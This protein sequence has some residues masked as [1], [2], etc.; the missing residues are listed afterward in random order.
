MELH[1]ERLILRPVEE[2]DAP[3]L[4]PLINDP[5]I[6]ANMLNIPHP[7]PKG[8][9]APWIRAARE[10]ME[11]NERIEMSIIL[12]ETGLPIGACGL[13]Q[14]CWDHLNG[15]I[16]YWLGKPYWGHG[17]M[18]EAVK[19]LVDFGFNDLDLYRVFGRCFVNNTASAKVL[20]KAGLIYE[21]CARGEVMKEGN[22]IDVLRFGL[23][24]PEFYSFDE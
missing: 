24:K 14:I 22:A 23:T 21:G 15:E 20:E 17:Y 8:A 10:S 3:V 5:D 13:C 18:T 11:Y 4:Y 7:Y 2:R 1:T 16:G 6:A 9:L 19:K 12:K